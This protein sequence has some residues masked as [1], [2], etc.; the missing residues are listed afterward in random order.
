MSSEHVVRPVV[1]ARPPAART[2]REV[3]S[4]ALRDISYEVLPLRGAEDL[5]LAHVPRDVSLTV[6]TTRRRGPDPTLDLA[7]RLRRHGYRVA[8]HISARDL[9]DDA[10]LDD[11]LGRLLAGGVTDAFVI[12]GDAPEPAGRFVD[13]LT[14]LRRLDELGRPFRSVGVAG[15]PEGHGLMDAGTIDRA[16]E[17]KVPHATHV[18]TQL[19]FDARRTVEWANRMTARGVRLPIRV[20]VPGVVSRQK[21]VRIAAGLGL[22]LSAR[23]LLKQQ[24]LLW[25]FFLPA[26][27]SPNRLVERLVPGLGAPDNHLRGLHVFTFNELERTEAWRRETLSRLG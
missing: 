5:V 26:G 22:G 13:A 24:S 25:R 20:G 3:L 4:G 2:R 16:L 27:Y 15:Y 19:C 9:R 8:P 6:T 7:V 21:L 11:V 14:V 17:S 23:F 18:I 12:G 1:P 10:H